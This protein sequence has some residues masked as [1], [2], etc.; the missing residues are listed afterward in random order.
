LWPPILKVNVM[1][2]IILIVGFSMGLG[3]G[4]IL[5]RDARVNATGWLHTLF[6]GLLIVA[7]IGYATRI[8]STRTPEVIIM[9]DT[10]T[11]CIKVT[12]EQL[13]DACRDIIQTFKATAYCP[14]SKC[15]GKF[16]DGIT[17]NGHKIRPG[18]AFVAA[19]KDIPFG[20]MMIVPGYNN[21]RP[22]PVLDRGG[23]ITAGRLDLFFST[24]QK[25]L[26]WGVKNVEVT[27]L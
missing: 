15:C 3:A 17:A 6:V 11:H 1:H 12:Q 10:Q 23:A 5:S 7:A 21:D 14:C 26:E 27:I 9:E 20:T 2:A 18:D 25:A 8:V 22:V 19:S 16:A 13:R 4:S 24:H